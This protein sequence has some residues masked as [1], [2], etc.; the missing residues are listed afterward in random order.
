MP[1]ENVEMRFTSRSQ[2]T[3]VNEDPAL[4]ADR[5]EGLPWLASYLWSALG[6]AH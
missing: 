5:L 2:Y 4:R 1:V 3:I 6:Q